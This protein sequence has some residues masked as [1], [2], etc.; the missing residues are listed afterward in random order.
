MSTWLWTP[1]YLWSHNVLILATAFVVL[2]KKAGNTDT[3]SWSRWKIF[4]ICGC[5]DEP[6][7]QRLFV[8]NVQHNVKNLHARNFLQSF[9]KEASKSQQSFLACCKQCTMLLS[10]SFSLEMQRARPGRAGPGWFDDRRIYVWLLHST[11]Q[12]WHRSLVSHFY[13][14]TRQLLACPPQARKQESTHG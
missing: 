14:C 3:K 4:I 5:S 8:R 7:T 1:L 12:S 2:I 11:C 9:W 6:V 13:I 10:F